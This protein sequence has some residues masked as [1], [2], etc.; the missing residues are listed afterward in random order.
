MTVSVAD[1]LG[2]Q[3]GS[4]ARKVAPK[5]APS[6]PSVIWVRFLLSPTCRPT[7]HVPGGILRAR[8]PESTDPSNQ[9]P[10]ATE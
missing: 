1:L 5:T 8:P 3:I 6:L 7:L 4:C 2:E 10:R 9:I